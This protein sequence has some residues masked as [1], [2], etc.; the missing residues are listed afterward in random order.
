MNDWMTSIFYFLSYDHCILHCYPP[1]SKASREVENFDWRKKK[2]YPYM[3]SKLYITNRLNNFSWTSWNYNMHENS[4]T[5]ACKIDTWQLW[6][7]L[8]KLWSHIFFMF[9]FE[10]K[11]TLF[12]YFFRFDSNFLKTVAQI[13][14]AN[15]TRQELKMIKKIE[16]FYAQLKRD[17]LFI[18]KSIRHI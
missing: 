4:T 11:Q 5:G 1:A 12:T 9:D 17:L 13:I 14:N 6:R 2:T 8:N 3:V 7:I 15:P 10:S 16:M 18:K